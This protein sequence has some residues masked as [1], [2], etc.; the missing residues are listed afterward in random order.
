MMP[1]LLISILL[2]TILIILLVLIYLLYQQDNEDCPIQSQ[3]NGI[4][5][6]ELVI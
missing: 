5:N 2:V 4:K 6:T 3:D 1:H